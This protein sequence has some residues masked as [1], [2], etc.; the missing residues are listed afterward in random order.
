T[1][2][3]QPDRETVAQQ[4]EQVRAEIDAIQ[5]RIDENLGNRDR[6]LEALAEAERAVGRARRAQ[7]ETDQALVAVRGE[8]SELEA[9]RVRLEDQVGERASELAMQLVAAYRQGSES[10]LK[11][12]LNQDDPRRLS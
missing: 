2:R 9:R 11:M 8:I 10:R 6:L 5:A 1:V 3:A 4:L 12:L 7:A